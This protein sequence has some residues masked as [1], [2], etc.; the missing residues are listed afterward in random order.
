[1]LQDW[2]H[3]L[4]DGLVPGSHNPKLG[5]G[6]FIFA[7]K[8]RRIEKINTALC[9]SFLFSQTRRGENRAHVDRDLAFFD[10]T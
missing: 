7:A 4:K 8:D 3:F 6:G 10:A 9:I 2:F 5:I 1:M